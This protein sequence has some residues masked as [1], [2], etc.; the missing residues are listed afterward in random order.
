MIGLEATFAAKLSS[1]DPKL[2]LG[3]A[4]NDPNP[5]SPTRHIGR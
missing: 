5:T 3:E 1:P 2:A 4:G